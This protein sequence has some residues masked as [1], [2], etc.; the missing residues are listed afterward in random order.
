[1]DV[2]YHLEINEWRDRRRLQL[3]VQD[4]RATGLDDAVACLSLGQGGL[5]SGEFEI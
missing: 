5:E 4:I 3:N 1:V 2:V